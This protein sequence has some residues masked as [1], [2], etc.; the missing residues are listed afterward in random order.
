MIYGKVNGRNT[1]HLLFLERIYMKKL[2]AII[3]VI[4]IIFLCACSNQQKAPETSTTTVAPAPLTNTLITTTEPQSTAAPIIITEW[5][6]DLLP[7]AFPAPPEGTF[8]FIIEQGDHETDEG[9]F[10][11]DWVR[12]KFTCPAHNFFS[13]TNSM[14]DL[15]Y[16]GATKEIV[17]GTYYSNGI[18]GFW[19][20]GKHLVRINSSELDDE[21][22][23]TVIIDVVPCTDNFP[24]QLLQYF[25]KFE[26][27]SVGDGDYCGHDSSGNFLTHSIDSGFSPYW[28]WSFRF[29]DGFV[30]VTYEEFEAYY[31]LL[32]EMD[33]SGVITSS[34]VDGC[35]I[36][37]VDV[38]K[39][40]DGYTYGAYMLFNQSLRTL[41]VV[42]TNDPSLVNAD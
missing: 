40:I 15:G 16:I 35:N 10:K 8:G 24:T 9:D 20:N 13:F 11:V 26:G 23:L 33:F 18:K 28:H 3:L 37:S 7:E 12:L 29:S 5:N 32:G 19:Q 34:T 39:T 22:N 17:N 41:D 30:G 1:V 31:T 14:L 25:P 42:Y 21:G 27:Y 38:E 6:T 2:H 4:T 36:L